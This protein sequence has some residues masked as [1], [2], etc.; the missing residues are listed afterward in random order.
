LVSAAAHLAAHAEICAGSAT[1]VAISETQVNEKS[2]LTDEFLR[3]LIS[4][5][6][7]DLLVGIVSRNNS[8]TIGNV[9]RAVEESLFRN[10]RRE[11][12]ALLH[13][14]GGS[15]DGTPQAALEASSLGSPNSFD[16][17][18]TMR[19]IT[20]NLNGKAGTGNMLRNIL[21]AA[22]LLH[23]RG[24]AVLSASME[25]ADPAW[26]VSLLSPVY[27]EG[28]DF[29][30]PLYSRHKFDGL[31][32]RNLLYP[33]S[34]AL[35]GRPIRELRATEF[36]FS[37]R[38]AAHFLSQDQWY[39]ENVEVS[40]EMGMAIRAMSGD[41]RCC[42]V[43]L[44]AKPQS[45]SSTNVVDVIRHTVSGFF[46]CLE[47]TD[48][49]W[50][51]GAEPQPLTTVGSDHQL[52]GGAIR[53]DRKKL[54]QMFQSGVA[55]LSQ[56]LSSILDPQT[57]GEMVRLVAVGE[58]EFRLTHALWVRA[59]YEFAVAYHHSRINR[60][61]LVQAFIPIYR[62]RVYSFLT[63]HR[64]SSS[65][66]LEADLENLCREYELQKSFFIEQWKGKGQGAS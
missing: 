31:L 42:Q 15:R 17:L 21:A 60:D 58:N 63:E 64:T 4:V 57:H 48:S 44:G 14:D 33:F 40:A 16:S 19:W 46:W 65:D 50:L 51:K 18:R 5:G 47:S 30:S 23:A 27:R 59:C 32:T 34:R 41:F 49:Y 56:L 24:C 1:W 43:Y 35:Y 13:V 28:C 10:F 29:V 54:L 38:L 52:T 39:D 62:G 66:A 55:Q 12:V 61:H 2:L 26:L 36:A 6:D 25:N 45:A 9:V 20:V 11:R 8:K 22:D 53:V 37:G 7:V 3:Q